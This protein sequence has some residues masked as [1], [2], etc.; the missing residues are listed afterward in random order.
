MRETDSFTLEICRGLCGGR[1]P[2]VLPWDEEFEKKLKETIL[3]SRWPEFL[4][5]RIKGPIKAHQRFKVS[6]AGCPNGCSRPQ[7]VDFGLIRAVKPEFVKELCTGCGACVQVCEEEAIILAESGIERVHPPVAG[8]H[9]FQ[10]YS[11]DRRKRLSPPRKYF[12]YKSIPADNDYPATGGCT[13]IELK[14]SQCLCCGACERICPS[15]AILTSEDGFRVMVGG[16]LGRHPRLATELPGIFSEKE[17]LHIL[18]KALTLYMEHYS[19]VKRF[20]DLFDFLPTPE[21]TS[22]LTPKKCG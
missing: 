18:G 3:K 8:N 20:G 16:K 5:A 21:L 15:Q 9:Q 7:I 13:R 2:N 22:T 6:V 1:C 11:R 17:V 4:G 12:S 19:R 10:P 14:S